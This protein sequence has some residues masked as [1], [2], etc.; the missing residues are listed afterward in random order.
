MTS[1]TIPF[2]AMDWTQGGHP[3]E[4]KKRAADGAASLL[5]FAPGF[6]DPNWCGGGHVGFV[7]E[8]R[9]GFELADGR[10]I[11]AAAGEG[12]ALAPGTRH[13]AYNAGESAVRLFIVPRG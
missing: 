10:K 4:R 7:L 11:V 12:F 1:G 2:D 3:L 6:A 5:L 8:G 13:R 9:L